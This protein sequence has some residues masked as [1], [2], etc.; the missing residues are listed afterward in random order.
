MNASWENTN[1]CQSEGNDCHSGGWGSAG[2]GGGTAPVGAEARG[3]DLMP[4]A[5]RGFSLKK[6]IPVPFDKKR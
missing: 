1:N 5:S 3:R 6:K 2:G 4:K